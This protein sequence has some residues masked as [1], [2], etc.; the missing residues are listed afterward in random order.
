[1]PEDNSSET[2]RITGWTPPYSPSGRPPADGGPPKS[3]IYGRPRGGQTGGR[4]RTQRRALVV[5]TAASVLAIVAY[6]TAA[7]MMLDSPVP[8]SPESRQRPLP[9][10]ELPPGSPAASDQSAPGGDPVAA[11]SPGRQRPRTTPPAAKPG[12]AKPSAGGPSAAPP[13][14]VTGSTVGLT[15]PS[16]PGHMLRHQNFI[17]RVDVI[18]AASP[19]IDRMDARFLIRTGRADPTCVSFEAANYPGYFLRHRDALLRLERAEENGPFDQQATFCPVTTEGGFVLRSGNLP[20]QHL[21][22]NGDWVRVE[23]TTADRATV[24]QAVPPL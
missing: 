4:D 14:L 19:P 12:A 2:Q 18:T 3:S 5:L 24:F 21:I 17:A 20:E 22:L 6:A 13:V 11:R 10:G 15:V 8:P 16:R 1:M 7:T 23:Q 9:A